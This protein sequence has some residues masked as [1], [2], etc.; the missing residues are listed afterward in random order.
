[1][2]VPKL[3]FRELQVKADLPSA[4]VGAGKTAT[5]ASSE[6]GEESDDVIDGD[7]EEAYSQ[8]IRSTMLEVEALSSS[9]GRAHG[10]SGAGANSSSKSMGDVAFVGAPSRGELNFWELNRAGSRSRSIG[11]M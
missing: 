1:M 4:G 5:A 10:D 6:E 8:F 3:D 11:H 2:L 9:P 7:G